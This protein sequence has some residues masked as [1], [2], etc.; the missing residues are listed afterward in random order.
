M[1]RRSLR[2]TDLEYSKVPRLCQ[3][4]Y[5]DETSDDYGRDVPAF[6]E[7]HPFHDEM[8]VYLGWGWESAAF[9][10]LI[11]AENLLIREAELIQ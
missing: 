11:A 4:W 2:M 6:F 10:I 1:K 8:K 9:K 5:E 3:V 7:C